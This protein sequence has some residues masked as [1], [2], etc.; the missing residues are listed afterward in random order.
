VASLVLLGIFALT[1]INAHHYPKR[2]RVMKFMA[3]FV[4]HHSFT[5]ATTGT[6]SF[7]RSAFLVCTTDEYL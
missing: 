4:I 2:H 7:K 3:M 5:A 1:T 6:G